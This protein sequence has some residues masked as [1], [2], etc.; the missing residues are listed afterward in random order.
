MHHEA[1]YS[2]PQADRR[3]DRRKKRDPR[4]RKA[5]SDAVGAESSIARDRRKTRCPVVPADE[6][7]NDSDAGGR[8]TAAD[9]AASPRRD[10]TGRGP[11]FSDSGE[12]A[13]YAADQ[14]RVLHVLPL[15]PGRNERIPA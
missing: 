4:G 9:G 7:E 8:E 13:R 2:S 11:H 1:G 5:A 10:E 6:Q 3:S 12:P 14:H 15:A